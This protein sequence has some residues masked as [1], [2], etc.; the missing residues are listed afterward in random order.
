MKKTLLCLTDTLYI[1]ICVKHF[2]IA[3]I[4]KKLKL[5]LLQLKVREGISK[6]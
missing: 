3:N 4:K 5:K 6:C 2:G 1:H